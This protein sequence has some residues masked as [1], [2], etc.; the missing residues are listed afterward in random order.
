[1]EHMGALDAAVILTKSGARGMV[2]PQNV[3]E[4]TGFESLRAGLS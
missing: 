1:M 2:G 4:S 3:G